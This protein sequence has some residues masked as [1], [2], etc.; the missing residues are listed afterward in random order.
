LKPQK[1]ISISIRRT[2]LFFAFV[3]LHFSFAFA[4]EKKDV[5]I[6]FEN[7]SV[8]VEK[9]STFT[10]F[11]V[12]ENKGSE[13]ITIQNIMPS[14]N[15]PGLLFYPKNGFILGAGQSKNLPVKLIAN[16]DFMK[17]RSNEIKFQV[18]Y[19][20]PTVTRT[21]NASFF[22]DKEENKNIAIYTSAYENFINP[23]APDSSILLTV[24]NQGYS[25]RTVKIDLQSIPDGLEMM[26]KQQTVSLEGLEKQTV[27][28]KIVVRKQNTLF[29][30]FNI[31]ATATD[32]L[33]NEI[34]G[35]NT[36]HLVILSNNRQIARGN[37]AVSGSNFAELSYNENSS[38]FNFLQL[39]GNTAFRV[40]ENLKSR[41]NIG[42]D[43][44]H[45]DGLYNLYDTWLEL[46]RKNTVLRVGNVNSNDYDYP[47]FGRGGKFSTKF[48]D[49]N[50]IEILALENNYNLSGTYF[51]Q[52]EGSTMVGAK[53]GFGN[54]KSFNGK[55][56]YIF[57]HDPRFNVDTQVTNAVSSFLIN[58]K[59]TI[60]TEAGLSHEKGLSN[61]DENV[62]ATMGANYDGKMGKWDIQSVNTFATSSYAGIKRGSFFSNQRIGR[63]FSASQRA[64]IQYQNSQVDPEF[65]SFQNAPI[66]TGN[67]ANLRYYFNSTESLGAGYQFSS[68][69][70][71]F[72]LSPKVERQ[73]TANFYTSQELFSYRMEANI[74]TTLGAHGLN[75]SAEYSYSKD[76]N[77]ADWFNSLKTTLSYRYKSFSLN[78]T[79]QWNAITVFDLNSYYNID[80]NFANYNVFTSY[81][82]QMLGNNLIGSFSAGTFYSE[83]YKNLNTNVSGNLE[84]KI[85]P[86]WSSTGYFNLSGYKSTAEYASSGS[87]Y[88]FRIGIKK[89][90]TAAT[91]LGNHK[92]TFQ[93]FEDKNFNGLLEA[94]ELVLANEIVKLDNFV[95]MT[96]KNGKVVFQNVPEGIYTLK[97]NESVGARLMMDPVIMVDKN[98][99]RKVGLVKNIKVSGKLTEIKQAYDVL[100]TDVTG[101]VVYA[102]GEDSVIHT[103][104]VNQK[105]EFEFFLKDGKY[106]LYIENDKYSYTQPN[107]TIQ[108][109]KEGFSGTV[110]FEYK[111]KDTTIK[112]KK[113]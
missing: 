61:K 3:L 68:K 99:N 87:Y 40:T 41:F 13:E 53:Y 57:D 44:Y 69:K 59:H 27:E 42:A 52:T 15:Y 112:V 65:L 43:Y 95:A 106:D 103:A 74:S 5:E 104:V 38:G 31:N 7:E 105:N 66:Q 9:G 14:E 63:Q 60:R 56:S 46:E 54:S 97:V 58:D 19:T 102:K 101:I 84:Y 50:Q 1:S 108:V 85:S 49:N 81:N 70:W 107:Q 47:V 94:G 45:E 29:P 22:V 39:R 28:I 25:K 32:L 72:L 109:T 90:F 111:K 91:A 33:N 18:S 34:V 4:Q 73:K 113:F 26:P 36:L 92:V 96:D 55:V 6:R 16:V 12:I 62:G 51:Q 93:L 35:S 11:L 100:E 77:K 98:I 30:E 110:V 75:W 67:T 8:A 78:G 76:N 17:L 21:E 20:T 79:A 89:Y 82:F 24:E 88:Q 71:N 83:L 37:E 23:A 2:I 10:N 80:R 48:G 64:F 86:S